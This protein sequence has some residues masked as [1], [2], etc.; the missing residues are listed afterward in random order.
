MLNA[1]DLKPI[2]EASIATVSEKVTLAEAK[3]AMDASKYCQDVFVTKAGTRNEAVTG[4]ITNSII[5]DNAK[6]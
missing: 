4:W 2:L 6:V 5:E 1:P 3:A